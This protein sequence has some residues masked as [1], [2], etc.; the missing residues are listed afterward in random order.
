MVTWAVPL[1]GLVKMPY[2]QS[3]T[4]ESLTLSLLA[5]NNEI[6]PANEN[7]RTTQPSI[8]R[9]PTVLATIPPP[10]L[11]WLFTVRPRRTTTSAEPAF[12][13]IPSPEKTDIP[14]YTPGAAVTVIDFVIVS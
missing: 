6:P 11:P 12:T 13:S 9:V 5:L 4:D 10:V 2:S 14:A 7:P 3:A 1:P 8:R